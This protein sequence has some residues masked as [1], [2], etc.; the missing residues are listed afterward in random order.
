M[1]A[2]SRARPAE[3]P[4]VAVFIDDLLTIFAPI[5]GG[6]SVNAGWVNVWLFRERLMFVLLSSINACLFCCPLLMNVNDP[7]HASL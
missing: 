4:Y 7:S 6:V 5:G 1:S 2:V 3:S